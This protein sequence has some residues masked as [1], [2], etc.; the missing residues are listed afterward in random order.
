[1]NVTLKFDETPT[2]HTKGA[3]RFMEAGD[4]ETHT[5]GNLYVRKSAVG[6]SC[7]ATL[8]IELSYDD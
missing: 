7:P 1:M 8:T 3:Y 6:S 5:I 4:P 2:K